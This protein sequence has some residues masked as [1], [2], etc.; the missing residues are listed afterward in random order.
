MSWQF[1]SPPVRFFLT[2]ISTTVYHYPVNIERSSRMNKRFPFDERTPMCYIVSRKSKRTAERKEDMEGNIMD[3]LEWRGDLAFT[4]SEMN[5]VDALI[6]SNLTYIN[7]PDVDEK[8]KPLYRCWKEWLGVPAD[9]Q[10]KGLDM[11]E[12]PVRALAEAAVR[13][14]RFKNL[15]LTRYRESSS[16]EMEKQFSAMTFL[17]PDNSLFIAF[18]GTDNSLVGWKEDFNM[19]FT[20]GTPSQLAAASYAEEIAR[21]WPECGINLGGHSKGG[22]LAVWAAVHLPPDVQT[23]VKHVYNN[24]GPGFIGDLQT[25]PGFLNIRDRI[26]SFVPESSIVGVLMG[27]CDYLTVESTGVSV[28]QHD[29]F[30]WKVCGKRFVYNTERT[31]SGKMIERSVNEMIASMNREELNDLVE[32]LYANLRL[33]EAKTLT[34]LKRHLLKRVITSIVTFRKFRFA[35][36]ERKKKGQELLN[37]LEKLG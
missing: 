28:L 13:T 34:D 12:K 1:F 20:S 29:P 25:S 7:Y 26:F 9:Q 18:R 3:Y 15:T 8:E 37:S 24:D 31:W 23:R 10:F 14:N 36:A 16:E 17:L 2:F 11:M 19:A 32:E 6:F 27:C 35:A 22:N 5:A 30:T 21:T 33:D 4:Q